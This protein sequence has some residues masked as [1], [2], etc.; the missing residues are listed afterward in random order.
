[1]SARRR[2]LRAALFAVPIAIALAVSST[3][4][5]E[6]ARMPDFPSWQDVQ[7][8]KA[9]VAATQAEIAKI[10]VILT[11]VEGESAALAKVAQQKAELSNQAQDALDAATAKVARLDAQAKQAAERADTSAV[12]AAGIIAQ[13]A[14][15]GGG[16]L[17]LNL[18]FG[19]GSS[20]DQLLSRLGTMN[21]VSKSSTAVLARAIFDRNNAQS[22]GGEAEAA[23]SRRAELATEAQQALADALKECFTL[24]GGA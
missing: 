6:A 7:A 18:L 3:M 10:Q 1:M 13:M 11:Q 14:R 2:P 23:Q 15:T 20:T 21:Q 4:T 5:A 12:R 19:S 8:A 16:D 17:T 24:A 9:S 22:M